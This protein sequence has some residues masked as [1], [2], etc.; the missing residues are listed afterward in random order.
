MKPKHFA[1]LLIAV[2]F[3]GWIVEKGLF[4]MRLYP[5]NWVGSK[6]DREPPEYP[7]F[8]EPQQFFKFHKGMR[9]ADDELHPRYG[10]G[11]KTIELEEAKARSSATIFARSNSTN[12]V[13]AFKER[14]PWNVPG[15]MR[16]ILV[17]P[18]DP[19]GDTW[20]AGAATGGI[21]KT[22]GGGK[23]WVE[24]S[25]DFSVYPISSFAMSGANPNIIYAGTGELIFNS[26]T[27]GDGIYKSND[28]GE[29][30]TQ[31][32]STAKNPDFSI[33]TR[34]IADPA[35]PKLLCYKK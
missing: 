3:A 30:W 33:V 16:A 32:V 34:I 29:T 4:G 35:N 12:G 14:G 18:T 15:R 25:Q 2:A 21:W 20:L 19:N 11:Y 22:S 7:G 10:A 9:M 28:G 1:V 26:S 17:L 27:I 13:I 23:T 31:L 6:K 8:D 5:N 24:K